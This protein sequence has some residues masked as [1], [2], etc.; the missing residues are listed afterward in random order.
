MLNV[1]EITKETMIDAYMKFKGTGLYFLLFVASIIFVL[2]NKKIKKNV[3]TIFGLFSVILFVIN[4]NPIFTNV[5]IKVLGNDVYWR[6]YWMLPLGLSIAFMFTYIVFST[7]EKSRRILLMVISCLLIVVSGDL[8]YNSKNFKRVNNYYKIEDELLDI[9]NYVSNDEEDYKKLV[10]PSDFEIY[11]RQIDGTIT[12][13]IGRV[14]GEPPEGDIIYNI[15]NANYK[16][17]RTYSVETNTNYVVLE[18]INIKPED[19]LSNY[20]FKEIY[21]NNKYTLYKLNQL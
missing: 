8:V 19:N 3:K 14:W 9:V 10:G 15:N 1:N 11:T 17:I 6:V 21:K 4:F 16:D 2:F 12:L 5:Y 20:N 7:N 13:A 18:N